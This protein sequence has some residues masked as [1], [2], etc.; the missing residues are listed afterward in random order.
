MSKDAV[1][2]DPVVLDLFSGIGGFSLGFIEEGFSPGA[3]VELDEGCR[4]VLGDKFSRTPAYADA[5][6]D[7]GLPVS[8]LVGSW[9]EKRPRRL[10][11]LADVRP[12]WVVVEN[13]A[14]RWRAW[15]PQLRLA[16]F[17]LGYASVC[18]QVSASEIGACH[19]RSRAF[20]I[21]HSDREQLRELSG[22]WGREGRKMADELAESWDSAPRGLG[23]DDGLPNWVER[24]HAL[25]NAV[26]PP[27]AQLIARAIRMTS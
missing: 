25:G 2:T 27:V 13:T 26:C 19:R 6:D 16:L 24:R 20:V 17:N 18:L 21:A 9:Q 3:F 4:A 5:R 7:S 15:V 22:W 11:E 14:H 10:S 23:T 1:P 12:D 8:G